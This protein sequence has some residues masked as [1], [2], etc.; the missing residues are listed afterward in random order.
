ML[1]LLHSKALHC[2]RLFYCLLTILAG[3]LAP[4]TVFAEPLCAATHIDRTAQVRYV[5]DG[6]TLHLASGEKIRLIGINTPELARDGRPAQP[7]A[8]A[9]RDRLRALVKQSQHRIGLRFDEQ[10]KDRYGRTLAHLY[11]AQGNSLSARLLEDGLATLLAVP[12]NLTGLDCYARV[13]RTA[14]LQKRGLWQLRRYRVVDAR[15]LSRKARGYHPVEGKI[16]RVG[17]GRRNLW[18][19][20]RGDIAFRIDKRDINYF[21]GIDLRSLTGRTVIGRGWLYSRKGERRMRLRSAY[22][23]Q[24]LPVSLDRID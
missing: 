22:D 24:I 1:Q 9:A 8:L 4:V 14:R 16:L 21:P 2:E 12:P 6:D 18:L 7:L 15:R 13:E 20:L 23:L 10:R 3:L 19:N 5:H 17:E 11:D